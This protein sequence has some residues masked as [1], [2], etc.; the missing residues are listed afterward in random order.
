MLNILFVAHNFH[1]KTKSNLFFV[2]ILKQH[3]NV[4]ETYLGPDR[5]AL[6]AP[7][8][9]I[10]TDYVVLWQLDYLAPIFINKGIK[11]LVVPMYDGSSNLG[12]AHWQLS[13][14]AY[15]LSFSYSLHKKI[16]QAD[17]KSL[18]VKYFPEPP[19][20]FVRDYSKLNAFWWMRQTNSG[21]NIENILTRWGSQLDSLHIHI[22]PD[23]P[24]SN[25]ERIKQE[26]QTSIPKPKA[27]DFEVSDPLKVSL[28]SWFD[29]AQEMTAV[30]QKCN[31]Y[32]APRASE[33]IGMGFLEAM[34]RGMVVLAHN[35]PTHNEYIAHSVSG[36]LY[37][38][39]TLEEQ[40]IA[41]YPETIGKIA[42]VTCERGY[43]K[44]QKQIP[45]IISYIKSMDYPK[46]SIGYLTKE[47]YSNILEGYFK[48]ISYYQ[49][50]IEKEASHLFYFK[51]RNKENEP[52]P[53]N[54]PQPLIPSCRPGRFYGFGSREAQK[55][56]YDGWGRGDQNK[57]WMNGT[58][59]SLCF[60]FDSIGGKNHYLIFKARTTNKNIKKDK[61]PLDVY[62]NQQKILSQHVTS[63]Y[64]E[65]EVKIPN[66]LL[67]KNEP[68]IVKFECLSTM[69]HK[70]F[71]YPI[72]CAF[73]S[74]KIVPRDQVQP[75]MSSEE[76][77]SV[78]TVFKK[79]SSLAEKLRNLI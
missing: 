55:F 41:E 76:K 42:R 58:E 11:T 8:F 26:I 51:Q 34:S 18:L 74:F 75:E 30:L 9:D 16:T 24:N 6:D 61:K 52:L 7:I 14:D 64:D 45:F 29:S 70:D 63:L 20:S 40:E 15:F 1:R 5:Y 50:A 17:C 3:F 19:G 49:K 54:Y 72:S 57:N 25:I 23:N 35:M 77:F 21:L 66:N 4:T 78:E 56:M 10:K 53:L 67:K 47:N 68:N 65:Y 48:G 12:E 71:D 62:L 2:E 32:I 44:W 27:S 46:R 13:R 69:V 31:V 79:T 36:F 28:S 73:E 39:H 59:A 60:S 22:V 37:D 43:E 33:G 38:H